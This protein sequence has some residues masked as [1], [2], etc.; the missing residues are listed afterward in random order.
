MASFQLF[1][2]Q[3]IHVL[4]FVCVITVCVRDMHAHIRSARN[5]DPNT[6]YR[7][8]KGAVTSREFEGNADRTQP[9]YENLVSMV[10]TGEVRWYDHVTRYTCLLHI[11][12]QATVDGKR[13]RGRQRKKRMD[14]IE[15]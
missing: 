10:N 7:K 11:L 1:E 15:E 13:C 4:L 9:P 5:E 3:I 2:D 12:L 6:C 8:I 14:D